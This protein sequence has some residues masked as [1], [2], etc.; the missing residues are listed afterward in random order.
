MGFLPHSSDIPDE[1]PYVILSLLS[2]LLSLDCPPPL[3]I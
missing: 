1:S 3:L 2:S